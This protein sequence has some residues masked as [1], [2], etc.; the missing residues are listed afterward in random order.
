[1]QDPPIDG[2]QPQQPGLACRGNS[3]VE[4]AHAD[5]LSR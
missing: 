5:Q 3:A 1:M 2:I 4:L